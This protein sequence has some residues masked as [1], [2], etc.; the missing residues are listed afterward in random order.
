MNEQTSNLDAL[1]ARAR[2]GAPL[3]T[4][5]EVESLLADAP[6]TQTPSKG[7]TTTF[8]I[9]IATLISIIAFSV[10]VNLSP[11]PV[12][13]VKAF[14]PLQLNQSQLAKLGIQIDDT[15]IYY[16]AKV[17]YIGTVELTVD[18]S[19]ELNAT[20]WRKDHLLERAADW[21]ETDF[22]LQSVTK[23]DGELMFVRNDRN[24]VHLFTAYVPLKIAMPVSS[25]DSLTFWFSPREALWEVLSEEQASLYRQ[26]AA[27]LLAGQGADPFVHRPFSSVDALRLD[28][29]ALNR[30]GFYFVDANLH[31]EA[32]VPSGERLVFDFGPEMQCITQVMNPD[33][34]GVFYQPY[35]QFVSDTNG[36]QSFRWSFDS[37]T[38]EKLSPAYL[39]KVR[40]QLVAIW[41]ERDFLQEPYL[42]WFEADE[43]FLQTIYGSEEAPSG[44]RYATWLKTQQPGLKPDGSFLQLSPNP[45]NSEVK[46]NFGKENEQPY[47][48]Q[49]LNLQGQVLRTSDWIDPD[50]QSRLGLTSFSSGIY[51]VV[52]RLK[53]GQQ[54]S[55]QL[56]IEN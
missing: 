37:E 47:R 55:K 29:E 35:T 44:E 48:W 10:F 9:M 31:Y 4:L 38:K 36:F 43:S 34:D 40:S 45:A 15:E 27:Q 24:P 3:M 26:Y 7:T 52:V 2:E 6:M 13:K 5:P 46:I 12:E 28:D 1:L 33:W 25:E 49:L 56:L 23:E 8:I 50:V 22:H 41:I 19:L 54:F 42:F 18:Q 32:V 30:L 51:L 53:N 16:A 14:P 11:S 17:P 20:T 39:G 21:P